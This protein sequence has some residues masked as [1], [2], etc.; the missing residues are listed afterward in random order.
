MAASAT[1]LTTYTIGQVLDAVASVTPQVLFK[2]Q[3]GYA[4]MTVQD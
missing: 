2:V 4:C 1:T 3:L